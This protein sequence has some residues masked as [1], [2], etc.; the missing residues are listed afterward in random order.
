MYAGGLLVEDLGICDLKKIFLK[1][2]LE[3]RHLHKICKLKALLCKSALF[4]CLDI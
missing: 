4:V 2:I 3:E 1:N